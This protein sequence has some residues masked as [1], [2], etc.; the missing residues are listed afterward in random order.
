MKI[1][2]MASTESTVVNGIIAKNSNSAEVR[3]ASTAAASWPDASPNSSMCRAA[4]PNTPMNRQAKIGGMTS[5]PTIYS[6]IVRPLDTRATNVPTNGD[7]AMT[8]AQ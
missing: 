8:Q 5:T 7:Q 1:N 3:L 6:R 2:A 4:P